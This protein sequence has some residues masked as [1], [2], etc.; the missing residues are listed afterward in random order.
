MKSVAG[1]IRTHRSEILSAWTEDAKQATSARNLSSPELA[2]MMPE[3][4]SLLGQETPSPDSRLSQAQQALIERH[5]SNR[6]R[7]GFNLN[8]ILTEFA[9][10]GRC[11]SRFL[12]AVANGD[13]PSVAE[14]ASLYGELYQTSTTVT[15]IFNEHLLEDEQTMKRYARLLEHIADE[16]L[17]LQDRSA[18]LFD[19]L[20][21]VLALILEAMGASTA[22][23]LLFDRADE[24]ITT[25]VIGA[26][27]AEL[28]QMAQ[29][30]EETTFSH[31]TRT[32]SAEVSV[33]P[34]LR[35]AGVHSLLRVGLAPLDT[36]R[37]VLYVGLKD[38]R[39]FS[40]EPC[41]C[42]CT[43]ARPC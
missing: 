29:S 2:S 25:A 24:W 18:P 40:Y 39:P 16:T 30:C 15:R 1:L 4:L 36:L 3:Y 42:R 9:L 27:A 14:V 17:G 28:E 6:L 5:L 37:C 13:R 11:V 41:R 31:S 32:A 43:R 8:E 35:S 10:L 21:E 34:T 20:N 33:T 22:A 26:G 38:K 7:E 19:R 23:L 12:Q